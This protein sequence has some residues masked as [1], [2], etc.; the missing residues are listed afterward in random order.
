M[1]L[2]LWTVAVATFD[3]GEGRKPSYSAYTLWYDKSWPGICLHD[4]RA[5]D[6]KGAKKI[7]IAAHK[8]G[9]GCRRQLPSVG[10]L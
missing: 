5:G 2:P 7:A 10:E 1:S 3:R 9:D 4:V 6:G 8:T